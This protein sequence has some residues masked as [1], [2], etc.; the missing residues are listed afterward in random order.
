MKPLRKSELPAFVKKALNPY[1]EEAATL[2]KEFKAE[3]NIL[4][5]ANLGGTLDDLRA[6]DRVCR[7]NRQAFDDGMILRAGF[8]LGEVLRRHYDGKYQ[9]DVRR[10]ALSL[11]IGEVSLFP[12]EKV[13]KIVA[14]KDAGTLEEYL[15]V[16]AKKIADS[17]GHG[18]SKEPP[19]AP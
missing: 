18:K 4:F 1:A 9:W 19:P 15:M 16:L 12:I 17:R 2:A 5:Q 14:E 13:R 10:N 3:A 7:F 11:R 8:Y 6:L